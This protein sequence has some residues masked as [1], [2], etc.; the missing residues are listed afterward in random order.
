MLFLFRLKLL[1]LFIK[2]VF[3]DRHHLD[4][5]MGS[6][7]APNGLDR[8]A[9]SPKVRRFVRPP[10]GIP[11]FVDDLTDDEIRPDAWLAAINDPD[12]IA[13]ARGFLEEQY[14]K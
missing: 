9:P 12:T 13:N 11:D 7:P 1:N 14:R 8:F 10:G 6:I 5:P 4:T 3:P 2:V